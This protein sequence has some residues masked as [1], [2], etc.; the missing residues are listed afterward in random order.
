MRQWKKSFSTVPFY[1]AVF[2]VAPVLWFLVAP[3]FSQDPVERKPGDDSFEGG[4]R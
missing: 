2:L 3:L 4:G 1:L